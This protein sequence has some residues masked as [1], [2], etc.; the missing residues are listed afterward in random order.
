MSRKL[1]DIISSARLSKYKSAMNKDL[2]K[3]LLLYQWNADVS[4]AF[5][6]MLQVLEV[7][8]RN[9][10][11]NAIT[12]IYG[13]N[14]AN[15]QTFQ[16]SLPDKND[17]R[18]QLKDKVKKHS[19]INKII[20]D[21]NFIFWQKLFTRRFTQNIWNKHLKTA[22]PN[23]GS[24][25]V[26]TLYGELDQIRKLRNRVAHHEPIFNR[27]L[28]DDLSLILKVI[29]YVDNEAEKWVLNNQTVTIWLARKPL[30]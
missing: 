21:M 16:L 2:N 24:T 4:G 22:F 17:Q 30:P 14:W 6:P 27:N 13:V 15:N 11:S 1:E 26:S 8:I 20:A 18:K 29:G 7:T 28:M 3:S 23:I 12:Q 5:L 19:D 10:V 25:S 9:A